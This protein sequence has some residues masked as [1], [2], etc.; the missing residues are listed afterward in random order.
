MQTSTEDITNPKGPRTQIMT[1]KSL[2]R[3]SRGI[4]RDIWGL[5]KGPRTQIIGV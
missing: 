4:H 5:C 3:G 2:S 1:L